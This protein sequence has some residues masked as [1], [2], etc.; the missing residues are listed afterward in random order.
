MNKII[1]WG[2][3]CIFSITPAIAQIEKYGSKDE[4]VAMVK[5][6]KVMFKK[7]GARKTFKAVTSQKYMFKDRDLYPF[8]YDLK[9]INVAHG[10][11]EVL[12]GKNLLELRDGENVP[13]LKLMIK[14][15]KN[16]GNGWVNYKWPNPVTGNLTSKSAYVEKL[17][18]DYFVGV[19]VYRN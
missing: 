16:K 2:M 13:L 18:K 19:G 4:A 6:V 10:V 17:G 15:V 14:A 1:L 7:Q 9:G 5:R 8:I 11:K 12:V 3:L